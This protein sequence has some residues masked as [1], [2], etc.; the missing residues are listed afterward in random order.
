MIGPDE[1]RRLARLAEL[2]VPESEAAGLAA[3]LDQIVSY[4][5]QLPAF[6]EGPPTA[7]VAE[8]S[9]LRPDLIA[10]MTLARL[11]M[12]FAPDFADGLFLVPRLPSMEG[13]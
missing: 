7:S 10:P 13:S 11:P 3:Q 6:D 4:V 5:G 9:R 2:D 12:E 1:L 8:P